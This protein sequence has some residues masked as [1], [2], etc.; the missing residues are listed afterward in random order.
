MTKRKKMIVAL[1]CAVSTMAGS[2]TA[3]AAEPAAP[4]E[5]AEAVYADTQGIS[6]QAVV[7]GKCGCILSIR[8]MSRHSCT[9]N[10]DWTHKSEYHVSYECETHSVSEFRQEIIN[11]SHSLYGPYED[12]GHNADNTHTHRGRCRSCGGTGIITLNCH[13]NPNSSGGHAQP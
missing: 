9:R 8:T 2:I 1:M 5:T 3:G 10:D 11:E 13:G 7:I 6:P 4:A 12:L